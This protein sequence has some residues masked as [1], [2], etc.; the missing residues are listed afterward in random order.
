MSTVFRVLGWLVLIGGMLL[1]IV[2]AI[3]V[4]SSYED[5]SS[6]AAALFI[7]VGGAVMSVLQGVLLLALAD[8]ILLFIDVERNTRATA[9]HVVKME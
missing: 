5:G 9:M 4:G 8:L 3:T 2:G 7:F 6:G 1:S